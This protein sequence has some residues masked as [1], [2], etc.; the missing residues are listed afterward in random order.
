MRCVTRRVHRA[1]TVPTTFGFVGRLVMPVRA[2]PDYHLHVCL[3][4]HTYA[5]CGYVYGCRLP[6]RFTPYPGPTFYHGYRAVPVTCGCYVPVYYTHTFTARSIHFS[7]VTTVLQVTLCGYRIHTVLGSWFTFTAVTRL[8]RRTPFA[9]ALLILRYTVRAHT[10]G[11]H[12]DVCGY[13]CVYVRTATGLLYHTRWFYHRTYL[14]HGWFWFGYWFPCRFALPRCRLPSL[15]HTCVLHRLV[16]AYHAIPVTHTAILLHWLIWITY[17][18]TLRLVGSG[19]SLHTTHFTHRVRVR[20]HVYRCAFYLVYSSRVLRLFAAH[21]SSRCLVCRVHRCGCAL[22][23][24]PY[25]VLVCIPL[26]PACTVWL[27]RGCLVTHILCYWVTFWLLHVLPPCVRYVL[28]FAVYRFTVT[29][30]WITPLRSTFGSAHTLPHLYATCRLPRTHCRTVTTTTH[31][32]TWILPFAPFGYLL[33]RHYSLVPS[34]FTFVPV[35]FMLPYTFTRSGSRLHIA[36][37]TFYRLRFTRYHNATSAFPAHALLVCYRTRLRTFGCVPH[38]HTPLYRWLHAVGSADLPHVRLLRLVRCRIAAHIALHTRSGY[39]T[40]RA[41][42]ACCGSAVG[43]LRLFCLPRGYVTTLRYA[44]YLG[45]TPFYVYAVLVPRATRC[46]A[47]RL[48]ACGCGCWLVVVVGY[49]G[50]RL[51]HRTVT[52][53]LHVTFAVTHTHAVGLYTLRL[54]FA[55]LHHLPLPHCHVRLLHLPALR[56]GSTYPSSGS[57][58]PV[59]VPLPC[60]GCGCYAFTAVYLPAVRAFAVLVGS[61][62]VTPAVTVHTRSGCTH[63]AA[64]RFL[65]RTLFTAVLRLRLR[66]VGLLRLRCGCTFLLHHIYSSL[67]RSPVATGYAHRTTTYGCCSGCRFWVSSGYRLPH[68][69]HTP[70]TCCSC[71]CRVLPRFAPHRLHHGYRA[72]YGCSSAVLVRCGY[73]TLVW[74]PFTPRFPTTT[75]VHRPG[76]TPHTGSAYV[77]GYG[78]HTGCRLL[79]LRTRTTR[80]L[81]G[82]TLRCR[83][84]AFF[85]YGYI[86]YYTTLR[87]LHTFVRVYATVLRFGCCG[88][89]LPSYVYRSLP[90][91]LPRLLVTVTCRFVTLYALCSCCLRLRLLVTTRTHIRLTRSAF[92]FGYVTYCRFVP[93]CPVTRFTYTVLR[94]VTRLRLRLRLVYAAVHAHTVQLHTFLPG[95]RG[96]LRLPTALHTFVATLLHTVTHTRIYHGSVTLLLRFTT[97]IPGSPVPVRGC[98]HATRLPLPLVAC[99]VYT[100]AVARTRTHTH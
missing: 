25:T 13:A 67:P 79:R 63:T 39:T 87:L 45:C 68:I 55:A 12:P 88:Y 75:A 48:F 61:G 52:H 28:H 41:P 4:T 49:A 37:R 78:C 51:P 29:A 43:W 71:R 46:V 17:L 53:R 1:V 76:Y 97:H 58:L 11:C 96:W 10:R 8:P 85:R 65:R 23:G 69:T 77:L 59:C 60:Y 14:P 6:Y 93:R 64:T 86:Y 47:H 82:Y 35:H 26:P 57:F 80:T 18:P 54:Q 74:L 24:F 89:T 95:S 99:A 5:A 100:H 16:Y 9:F 42:P 66:L 21:C 31:G 22:F 72:C 73:V 20:T 56:S 33:V 81:P 62:Y 34:R 40:P 94:L 32:C 84:A 90:P 50:C 83:F 38:T 3:R 19:C 2:C 27:S 30:Y 44:V 98:A 91:V 15:P 36:C 7:L 70:H 92:A